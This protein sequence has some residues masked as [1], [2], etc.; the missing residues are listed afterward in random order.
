GGALVAEG[1]YD[2]AIEKYQRLEELGQADKMQEKISFAR[3]E[4]KAEQQLKLAR[5][6]LT[7]GDKE[8]AKEIVAKIEPGTRAAVEARNLR[9]QLGL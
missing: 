5:Q 7:E 9:K 6:K 3:Q 8:A 2:E 4:Q 1:K